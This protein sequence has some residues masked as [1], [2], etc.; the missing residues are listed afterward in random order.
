MAEYDADGDGILSASEVD[1]APGIEFAKDRIDGD[2]DGSVTAA[3]LRDFI[4]QR[5]VDAD[6]G[7]VRVAV[8]VYH[9]R[10]PLE[11]AT[12]TLE[13]EPFLQ[14]VLKGA[15]GETDSEGYA[16]LALAPEDIPHENVR[17]GV[18]PGLY[19]V[20]ISKEVNGKELLPAKYNTE[21]TLGIE[22]ASRAAYG[23]G[24]CRIDLK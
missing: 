21:T 19:L 16:P 18:P 6:A 11:G 17:S 2:Q 15:S 5:W 13:P 9:R 10:R 8:E 4:Q 3:E 23:P 24:P 20:R 1:H 12:V 7:I 22:V 14:D